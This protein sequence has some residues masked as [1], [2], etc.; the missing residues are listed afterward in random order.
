[1]GN[2][3]SSITSGMRSTMEETQEKM[4]LRQIELNA[5][6]VRE[7]QMAMQI[8]SQRD[9]F[10]FFAAFCTVAFPAL[11]IKKF[12]APILPLSFVLAYQGDMAY[13]NKIERIRADAEDILQG[14]RRE[15]YLPLPLGEP[16][17][18]GIDEALRA[19]GKL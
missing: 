19:K 16:T 7:R 9:F 4:L 2:L 3:S 13:G 18:T 10:H 6:Q 11:I 17:V 5:S 14:E 1:M 8:A 12:P 15:K